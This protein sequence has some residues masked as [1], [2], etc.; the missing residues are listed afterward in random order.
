MSTGTMS[1]SKGAF[2]ELSKAAQKLKCFD[3]V[4]EFLSLF[5]THGT[6]TK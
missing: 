4:F 2:D 3:R 5:L 6:Y 1:L